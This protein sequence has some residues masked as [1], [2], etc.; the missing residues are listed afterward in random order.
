MCVSLSHRSYRRWASPATWAVSDVFVCHTD[1][2]GDGQVLPPGLF[3]MCVSVTQ[4]LQAMGKSYHP[5][6][7]WC[8]CLSHRSCRRWASPTTRAVSDVCLSHRSCRR[9]ASRTT[10]A[11]SAAASVMSVSTAFLSRS[12]SVTRSTASLTTIGEWA[13]ALLRATGPVHRPRHGPLALSR[14][15]G[16]AN[17]QQPPAP[18]WAGHGPLALSTGRVMGHWSFHGP[19]A[20]S[21]ARHK[22]TRSQQIYFDANIIYTKCDLRQSYY[23]AIIK[24]HIFHVPLWRLFQLELSLIYYTFLLIHFNNNGNLWNVQRTDSVFQGLRPEV[25][26]MWQGNHP[27]RG[28]GGDRPG[29]VNWPRFPRRLLPLWG[30][31]RHWSPNSSAPRSFASR[32]GVLV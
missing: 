15:T 30:R 29:R 6:C 27:R 4:I 13:Q 31:W 17:G 12:T 26:S 14:T 16:P 5:G 20:P 9:W 25:R 22:Q 32:L 3:L 1:P 2:A 28:Y 11:V 18:S 23:H 8:V 7:F 10:R 24:K 21:P 19:P